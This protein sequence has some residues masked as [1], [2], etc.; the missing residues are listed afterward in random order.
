MSYSVSQHRTDTEERRLNLL[1]NLKILDT[2]QESIYDETVVLAAEIAQTEVALVSLVDSKRQWFKAKIGLEA[3]ETPREISFCQHA[4]ENDHPFIVSDA[5][6]DSRFSEN[7]L[8]TGD[9]RIRFYAGFPL[10]MPDGLR[11]GTLC[12]ISRMPKELTDVQSR[13]LQQLAKQVTHHLNGRLV[14]QQKEE[15]RNAL[16]EQQLI[17][18][19]TSKMAALGEMAAGIAHEI[20]NPLAV[21]LGWAGELSEL[22]A[23]SQLD[24]EKIAQIG[25]SIEKVGLRIAR[26]VGA[27]RSFARD[28]QQLQPEVSRLMNI[29][30]DTLELCQQRFK[31]HDVALVIA[32]PRAD[33]MLKCR[34]V[35][36]SQV[37]LNLLNNSFDSVVQRPEKWIHLI[38]QE[39]DS[40]I[41]VSV[42]DSGPPIPAETQ[43]RLMTPFFT[44]K[45]AGVGTGLG[46]SISQRIAYAH[47]GS[48]KFRNEANHPCFT[49]CLPKA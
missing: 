24:G 45:P 44:T 4:I 26:T 15:M 18:A 36:I 7:P 49:L 34:S 29:I 3:S 33:L 16:I 47:G 46:L 5:R 1:E 20:N 42:R 28:G 43:E 31:Q 27:L 12:V 2:A 25:T 37:L 17:I 39:T 48:I 21:I 19:G 41:E 22:S 14:E 10:I 23:T 30:D 35:E 9:P 11:M 13:S 6:R 40:G 32:R 38:C 8:V